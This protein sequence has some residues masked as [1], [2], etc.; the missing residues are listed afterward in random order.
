MAANQ[1][2]GLV[3]AHYRTHRGRAGKPWVD[4][5]HM[6]GAIHKTALNIDSTTRTEGLRDPFAR[7]GNLGESTDVAMA[8]TRADYQPLSKLRS[9]GPVA[10][11]GPRI[12]GTVQLPMQRNRIDEIAIHVVKNTDR[13]LVLEC[14]DVFLNDE[15]IMPN[16]KVFGTNSQA[17]SD[18]GQC[19]SLLNH[20]RKSA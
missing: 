15:F 13:I 16:P 7:S 11:S 2:I 19:N 4:F 12:E 3:V 9:S 14:S 6:N 17:R 5:E 8:H 10:D 20:L 1:D 18:P